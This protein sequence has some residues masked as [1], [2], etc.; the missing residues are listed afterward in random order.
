MNFRHYL[1]AILLV[2]FGCGKT[3][4]SGNARTGGGGSKQS[5]EAVPADSASPSTADATSGSEEA[6]SATIDEAKTEAG[7][8]ALSVDASPVDGGIAAGH[9]DLDTSITNYAVDKGKTDSH[10]HAYDDQYNVLYADFLNLLAPAQVNIAEA[11]TDPAKRFLLIIVNADL[12]PAGIV[13]V[14]G[15]LSKAQDF[16]TASHAGLDTPAG[17]HAY[18]L[19]EPKTAGDLQLKDLRIYFGKDA[20]EKA[21]IVG[22]TPSVVQKNVAGPKGEYRAGALTLQALD[23][24]KFAIDPKTGAATVGEGGL[25]WEAMMYWHNKD[26]EAPG[27]N[28]DDD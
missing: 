15:T 24:D 16:A 3:S 19:G 2:A 8:Q 10:T 1:A 9:F 28:Q 14:N 6:N 7:D 11:M 17:L 25:L 22:L 26:D 12:S 21:G 18:T 23:I 13:S 4:F 27:K 20:I 5:D